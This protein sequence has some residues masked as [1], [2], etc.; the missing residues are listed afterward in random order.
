V[1]GVG[2]RVMMNRKSVAVHV[3]DYTS[4]RYD[5]CAVIIMSFCVITSIN[6]L[7]YNG[8][9]SNLCVITRNYT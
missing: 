2:E 8:D 5:Y 1:R 4:S 6:K 9:T 7:L 3:N